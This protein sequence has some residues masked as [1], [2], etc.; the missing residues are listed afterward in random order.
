MIFLTTQ[1]KTQLLREYYV[2]NSCYFRVLSSSTSTC[3]VRRSGI[4][5]PANMQKAFR[6]SLGDGIMPEAKDPQ[7]K[8]IVND[9]VKNDIKNNTNNLNNCHLPMNVENA[10]DPLN[11]S[12]SLENDNVNNIDKDGSQIRSGMTIIPQEVL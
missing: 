9:I 2:N 3:N 1:S 11:N 5:I 10:G 8:N 12:Q 6:N 4:V 7:K